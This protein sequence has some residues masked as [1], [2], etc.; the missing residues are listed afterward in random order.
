[1]CADVVHRSV[2]CSAAQLERWHKRLER[3]CADDQSQGDRTQQQQL[4]RLLQHGGDSN[5]DRGRDRDRDGDSGF[6]A[7]LLRAREEVRGVLRVL[8]ACQSGRWL[9]C[10]QVL[11]VA[12]SKRSS[13]LASSLARVS[14]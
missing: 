8:L 12:A 9:E 3:L 7:E 4:L 10:G 13:V 6:L 1:M 2:T 11:C 5:A 14:E